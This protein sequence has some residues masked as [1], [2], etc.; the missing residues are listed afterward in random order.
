MYADTKAEYDSYAEF[1]LEVSQDWA[2]APFGTVFSYENLPDEVLDYEFYN[3]YGRADAPCV[4]AWSNSY[5]IHIHEYD[6]A[7]Y[8]KWLPRFPEQFK[9]QDR[10]A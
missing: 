4:I 10:F 5:I 1:D 3:G 7:Q 8:L 2:V 9:L 6:G